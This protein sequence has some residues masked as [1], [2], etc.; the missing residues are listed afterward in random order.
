VAK[1]KV[2]AGRT[3]WTKEYVRL[4]KKIFRNRPTAEVAEELGRTVTSVQ[5]RA[6]SLGLVKTKKYLKSIG[7]GRSGADRPL[8]HL[9]RPYPLHGVLNR[10]A[11][12]AVDCA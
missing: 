10:A 5:A 11:L 9:F 7:K 2:T 1:R 12:K 3:V 4:L 8:C 6:S